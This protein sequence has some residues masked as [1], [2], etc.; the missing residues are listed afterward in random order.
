M[1]H[2]HWEGHLLVAS[3]QASPLEPELRTSAVIAFVGCRHSALLVAGVKMAQQDSDSTESEPNAYDEAGGHH[4]P[5]PYRSLV[6]R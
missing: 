1:L 4:H 6:A 3:V 2:G 5:S